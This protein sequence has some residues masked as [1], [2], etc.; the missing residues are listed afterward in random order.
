MYASVCENLTLPFVSHYSRLGFIRRQAERVYAQ[1]LAGRL[2]IRAPRLDTSVA[3]LSGGNQ[4]KVALGKWL[5]RAPTVLLADEPTRGVDVGARSK[6]YEIIRS[7]GDAGVAVL[8][9]SSEVEEIMG[10]AHRIL[11]MHRGR[12]VR[13]LPGDAGEDAILTAAFGSG[14]T[15]RLL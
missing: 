14:L 12:I 11:V 2:D 4:Q 13:E 5:G 7:L 6:I 9:I 10:L 3:N 1:E 8:L 15:S